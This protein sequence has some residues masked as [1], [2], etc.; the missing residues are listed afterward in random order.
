VCSR[1]SIYFKRYFVWLK[2]FGL[3][4][5]GLVSNYKQH[6]LSSTEVRK[7]CYLLAERCR[8]CLF[9]CIRVEGGVKYTKHFKGG[10]SCKSLGTPALEATGPWIYCFTSVQVQ[11]T[12]ILLYIAEVW[13]SRGGKDICYSLLCLRPC[14]PVGGWQR[15]GRIFRFRCTFHRNL[16]TRLQD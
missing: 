14:S 7:A 11:Y 16:V 10:A 5:F 6:I 3:V 12:K 1:L 9:D 13:D 4:W 15:F 2:I 8:M